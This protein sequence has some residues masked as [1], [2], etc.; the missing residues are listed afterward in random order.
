MARARIKRGATFEAACTHRD[1]A[2]AAVNLTGWTLTSQV[3]TQGGRLVG[4]LTVTLADQV[5][6]PGSFTVRA[7][8]AATAA[9]PLDVLIWDIRFDAPTG[10]VF[11]ETVELEV[12]RQVT[13]PAA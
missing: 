9:W 1:A 11:T 4:D 7:E 8:A 10:V 6:D 5:A 12:L 2:G 13:E 3:R